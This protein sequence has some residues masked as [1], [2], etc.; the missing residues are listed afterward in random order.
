MIIYDQMTLITDDTQRIL[1]NLHNGHYLVP[2]K[3][4]VYLESKFI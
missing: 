2:G 4:G 3:R 1:Q